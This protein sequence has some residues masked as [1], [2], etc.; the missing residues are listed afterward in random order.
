VDRCD[1]VVTAVTMAMHIAIG[2][3]KKLVLFNNIFNPYEFELYGR[4]RILAPERPC[5]C[6]FR[7]RCLQERSCMETLRPETAHRTVRL[8]LDG[9]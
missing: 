4:G 6:F 3:G 7:P 8:L 9:A 5:T 2:L 1:L